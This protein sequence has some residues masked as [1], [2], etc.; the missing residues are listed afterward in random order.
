M[1]TPA[2]RLVRRP[3]FAARPLEWAS[4]PPT[5]RPRQP[6]AT[7][8]YP[9]VQHHLKTF[10]A[11]AAE[12]DPLGHALP[13]WVERDFRAN[14]RCG[15]LAHGFAHA[16]CGDCGHERLVPFSCK[17]RGICPSCNT[18]R[19]AEVAAHLTDHVLPHLP[20]RQWVL[21]VP[22]RLQPYLHHDPEVAGE[23]LGIFLRAI[24]TTLRHT[25]PGAPAEAQL[26]AVSFL[27]RFGSAVNLQF[28]ELRSKVSRTCVS[29]CYAP[30][31]LGRSVTRSLRCSRAPQGGCTPFY[32]STR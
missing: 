18:R 7:P 26:G 9:V 6:T 20:V 32:P 17:G 4:S 14:L 11:Q 30:H 12:A 28:L 19:M 1:A 15:I 23:V 3:P 27:H 24:R 21:S 5:Y 8:L 16:R 13:Y 29:M 2:K 10:L 22:K 31:P 25:S